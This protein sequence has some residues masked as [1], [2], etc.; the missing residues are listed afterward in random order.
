MVGEEV[1]GHVEAEVLVQHLGEDVAEIGG[2]LEVTALVE[3]R[4][5]QARPLAVNAPAGDLPALLLRLHL[6]T[7]AVNSLVGV[8]ATETVRVDLLLAECLGVVA[9]VRSQPDE[10]N[11]DF[12]TAAEV[13]RL[14][15]VPELLP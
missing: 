10:S 15:I 2:D 14:G 3:V 7:E 8:F 1:L 6:T 4:L 13:M 9:R 5:G 12:T 11:P